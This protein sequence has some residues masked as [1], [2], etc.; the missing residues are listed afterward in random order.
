MAHKLF[1]NVNILYEQIETQ[2]ADQSPDEGPGAQMA[3]RTIVPDSMTFRCC[4]GPRQAF[5]V[6]TCGFL[7]CYACKFPHSKLCCSPSRCRGPIER[8]TN[9][10][11]VCPD[12]SVARNAPSMVQ[13]ILNI[14]SESKNIW[15]LASRWYDH[16]ERFYKSPNVTRVGT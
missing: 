12:L 10:R 14:L 6:Y 13:R 3:V 5:C 9:V 15:P 7:A 16:L 8:D 1:W 11:R 2:Y 4:Q